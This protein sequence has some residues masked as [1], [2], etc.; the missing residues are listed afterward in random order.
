M[1]VVHLRRSA[2]NSLPQGLPGKT[3][4]Q[5]F[6]T[7]LDFKSIKYLWAFQGLCPLEFCHRCQEFQNQ[8]PISQVCDW[9]WLPHPILRARCPL[10]RIKWELG[11]EEKEER[12][13]VYS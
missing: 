4:A 10:E 6:V 11:R 8:I 3:H 7:M 1:D 2:S 12:C 9:H 5:L 13:F